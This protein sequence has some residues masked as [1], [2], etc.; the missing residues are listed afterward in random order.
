MLMAQKYPMAVVTAP[1]QVALEE[2]SLPGLGSQ[3]VLIDVKACALCG[4]DLHIFKGKHPAAPLPV[5]VGHEIAG[6]VAAVGAQVMR[7]RVGDRVA[8]EPVVVCGAC[9]FCL[10]GDYHLCQNI[11]FQYRQG[12]GG[13]TTH[14]IAEERWVHRLP[15]GLPFEQGALIEPLAVA[16]HAVGRSGLRLGDRTAVFGDGPIGLLLQLVA[17]RVSQ[18]E[19]Y[20]IGIQEHRLARAR[21]W[22]AAAVI[23]NLREEALE[24]LDELTGGLGVQVAFEAV[25][26]QTTLVQT[27]RSLSK[28]GTGVLVG[29]FEEP[30]VSLPANLFIQKEIALIGSQGYRWDFQRAIKLVKSGALPLEEMITHVFPLGSVQEA[31]EC[32]LDPGN[33]AVKVVVKTA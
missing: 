18:G 13:L 24:R 28:G 2:R 31:F 23:D 1:G 30:E 26:L 32:L 15:P 29:I 20:V 22:G 4:S 3:Q 25:G 10:R 7:L 6:E 11:S 9:H 16:V 27:L 33:R 19:V 5:A 21:D 14:F 12:Q 8:V 17:G